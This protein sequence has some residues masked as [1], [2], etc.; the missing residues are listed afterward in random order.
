MPSK[1]KSESDRG[2]DAVAESRRWKEAVARETQGMTAA[3]RM[4]YFR[5]HSS[6]PAIAARE[7]HR[8]DTSCIVREEP[9]T[10]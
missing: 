9:P 3:E 7:N 1:T 4:A 2:F 8:E 5:S 6:V 10:P